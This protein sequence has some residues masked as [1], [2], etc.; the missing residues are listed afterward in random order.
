MRACASR[1]VTHTMVNWQGLP[2]RGFPI[3]FHGVRGR[4][5]RAKH[6]YSYYNVLEASIVRDYC[7]KLTEDI[8]QKTCEWRLFHCSLGSLCTSV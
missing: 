4:E 6:S 5:Q 3:V 7:R 2:K 8:E 1:D